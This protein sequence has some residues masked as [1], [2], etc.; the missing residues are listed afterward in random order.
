MSFPPK[1]IGI[2]FLMSGALLNS[3][4]ADR[5]ELIAKG[6]WLGTLL[7]QATSTGIAS[8][9]SSIRLNIL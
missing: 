4:P 6:K 3:S 2:I 9:N 1:Y 8:L 7:F 5:P